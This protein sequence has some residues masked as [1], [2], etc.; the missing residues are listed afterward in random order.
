MPTRHYE[1]FMLDGGSMKSD[2]T[3]ILL[4]KH[5]QDTLFGEHEMDLELA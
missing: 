2:G 3:S 5:N 1:S 4:L